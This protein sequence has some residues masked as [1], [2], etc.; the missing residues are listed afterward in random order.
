[1]ATEESKLKKWFLN[2]ISIFDFKLILVN[3]D[4]FTFNDIAEIII[5][6]SEKFKIEK[7]ELSTSRLGININQQSFINIGTFNDF[8]VDIG[9]L[10]YN[11]GTTSGIISI[12]KRSINYDEKIID[13][14]LET[15]KYMIN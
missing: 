14:G 15:G 6:K 4:I 11:D 3:K 10:G 7:I 1:M 5:S 8:K 2:Q 9:N 12:D 13:N